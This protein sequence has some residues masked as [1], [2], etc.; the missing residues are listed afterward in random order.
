MVEPISFVQSIIDHCAGDDSTEFAGRHVV[1]E[2]ARDVLHHQVTTP[3][4]PL[5]VNIEGLDGVGKSTCLLNLVNELAARGV[6]SVCFRTPTP[7]LAPFRTYF[8]QQPPGLRRAYYQLCNVHL[9][10][11]LEDGAAGDA[12]VAL[13]DRWWPSTYAYGNAEA[14]AAGLYACVPI[15]W[16]TSIVAPDLCFVLLLSDDSERARR[17]ETR[18]EMQTSEELALRRDE[19][20]RSAVVRLYQ[21]VE[22]ATEIDAGRH[23]LAI[24]SDIATTIV[25]RLAQK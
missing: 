21:S 1:L 9:S 10:Q 22:L 23:P 15:R 19:A 13:V 3:P 25:Q 24:A 2:L 20:F 7:Q 5:I 8:D 4:L 16:P 17:I 12:A 6:T 14:N 11:L 18:G